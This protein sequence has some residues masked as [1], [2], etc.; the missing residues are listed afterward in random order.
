MQIRWLAAGGCCQ[1]Y[2]QA[3]ASGSLGRLS[4]VNMQR[5]TCFHVYESV[6][7]LCALCALRSLHA[8]HIYIYICVLASIFVSFVCL[9]NFPCSVG[10]V[11][12]T[13]WQMTG[14]NTTLEKGLRRRPLL[15]EHARR[16]DKIT[17]A[18]A[19]VGF[20]LG[21]CPLYLFE[22]MLCASVSLFRWVCSCASERSI[23][24][25]F[26]FVHVQ[27]SGCV[28]VSLRVCVFLRASFFLV[29]VHSWCGVCDVLFVWC[30]AGQRVCFS[31]C[32]DVLS[33][34]WCVVCDAWCVVCG[35]V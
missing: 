5:S 4:L 13:S 1:G 6:C 26:V 3:T 21:V 9:A 29:L 33:R 32:L 12:G 28:F 10:L 31:V 2:R 18:S 22:L 20:A 34:V 17:P 30:V 19:P 35:V 7:A 25:V 8:L 23:L 27:V 11:C 24:R 14:L 15:A 16:L